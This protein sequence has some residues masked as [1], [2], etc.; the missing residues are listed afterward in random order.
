MLTTASGSHWKSMRSILTPTFTSGKMKNMF[1]LVQEKAR[2]L[3]RFCEP[4]SENG[5]NIEFMSVLGKVSLDIIGTF[6][7]G[8]EIDSLNGGNK[9]F[10]EAASKVNKPTLEVFGK[11][12]LMTFFPWVAKTMKVKFMSKENKFLEDIMK[13]TLKKRKTGAKR[14]DFVDLLL[15]S[16]EIEGERKEEEDDKKK[17]FSK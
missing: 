4:S 13:E 10:A 3:I 6:V 9:D 16:S 5:L 12:I 2:G 11:F 7:F 1:P 17:K 15:E 8:L 14:G